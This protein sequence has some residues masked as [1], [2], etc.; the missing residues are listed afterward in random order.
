M[1]EIKYG[2]ISKVDADCLEKT[3]DLICNEFKGEEIN[4]VEIGLFDCGTATGIFDYAWQTHPNDIK[5]INYIGIDN[6][7]DKPINPPDWLTYIKGDSNSVYNQLEDE[8][9]NMIIVDGNHSFPYVISDWHCYKNKL[10]KGGYFC[11]HDGAPQAQGLDWQ[12]MGDEKDTDMCIS[13]RK[14]LTEI[15]VLSPI[16]E[17]PN[18]IYHWY[19][20][21]Q[22]VFDVFDSNDR[23]G[24]LIVFKKMN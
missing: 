14:A 23:C 9:Q 11:F 5:G 22:K 1:S 19:H 15:G 12:R 17:H 8:S 7:K 3:I 18:L 24:G 13:V 6:E 4:I 2:L 10:K 16:Q 21:W 20:G